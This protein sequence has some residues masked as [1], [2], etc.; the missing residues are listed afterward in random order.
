MT[1][2]KYPDQLLHN[3][4]DML[5][6]TGSVKS[7]AI[8]RAL[9]S[10]PRHLFVDRMHPL[11]KRKRYIEVDPTRPTKGQL[12]RIYSDE[13]LLSRMNPPSSTSQP[14]LVVHMLEV[15]CARPGH[16]VFE[17]G[18]GT[19]WNA[20]LLSHLVGPS[21]QVISMDIQP[22]VTHAARRHL[23]RQG[24][25]NV[26]VVTGDA[27]R[28][29]ARG[30]PYDRLITT[31]TCP[32]VFP[33]WWEQLTLGGV[34]VMTLSDLP[35]ESQCLML[36]LQKRK[37][38][39][40]GEVVSLPGFM[41]FT[42]KHGIA[43]QWEQAQKLVEEFAGKRPTIRERA[44]W[45]S[46]PDGRKNMLRRDLA[47]F[48]QL[49]GCTVIPN[50]MDTF[51]LM[52]HKGRDICI[53]GENHIVSYRGRECFDKFKKIQAK[54]LALGAPSRQKYCVEVWPD[55]VRRNHRRNSWELRIGAMDFIFSLK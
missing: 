45:A 4:V 14:S 51:A 13:A 34:M 39:L 50:M 12:A 2:T 23:K 30:A 18:A 31:V 33:A 35:G 17:V 11:G 49:Q 47:F 41:L 1:E 16:R 6:A 20:A 21:G 27:A 9:Q 24:A 32:A 52:T 29:Y 3:F 19:G 15:L 25:K 53:A 28:G 5:K 42:G 8:E 7:K 38:R 26:R 54:W 37:D 10:T 46:I 43:P 44:F 36:R 55:T 22:D 48:A 40:R